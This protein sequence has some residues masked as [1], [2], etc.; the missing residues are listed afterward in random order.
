MIN[1]KNLES[2]GVE[3]CGGLKWKFKFLGIFL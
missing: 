1:N 3:G 2:G